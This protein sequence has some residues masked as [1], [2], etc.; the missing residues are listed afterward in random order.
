MKTLRACDG[1]AFYSNQQAFTSVEHP[2]RS[3]YLL[4]AVY[5]GVMKTAYNI[6]GGSI[7]SSLA[8]RTK[9]QNLP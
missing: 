6:L 3:T 9:I 8:A 5:A 4:S 2:H 7:Y 1:F